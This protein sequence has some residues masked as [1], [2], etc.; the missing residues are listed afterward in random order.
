MI[1]RL[2]TVVRNLRARNSFECSECT[3]G[4]A[5]VKFILFQRMIYSLFRKLN[6]NPLTGPGLS[7]I[8]D[9]SV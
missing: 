7:V 6:T 2:L 1:R 9:P 8:L 5:F 4:A 3:G